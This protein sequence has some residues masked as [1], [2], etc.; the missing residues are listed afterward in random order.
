MSPKVKYRLY[1]ALFTPLAWLP[2]PVLY[3][4]SSALAMLFEHVLKYRRKIVRKNLRNAFPEKSE[5]ELR[6]IEHDFY[7]QFADNIVETVKLLS[8]SDR[9]ADRRIEVRGVEGPNAVAAEGKPVVLYLGHYGNW[10]YVTKI[11][12]HLD[13]P[14]LTQIYKPLR[15]KG[16]DLLMLKIRS[17]FGGTSLPQHYAVR[18]LIRW[19]REGKPWVCGFIADQRSNSHVNHHETIWLSQP[20]QFNPGGEEVGRHTGAEYFYID[21]E[22]PHRGHYVLTFKKIQP[23]DMNVDSPYTREYLRMLEQTIRRRPGLWL[24]SHRRWKWAA[25]SSLNN[26]ENIKKS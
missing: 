6:E 4:F 1:R 10:E 24:W 17:R 20:T 9:E 14:V 25:E 23:G 21:V 5:R 15:D 12:W 2:L 7:R 8:I 13:F 18:Q 16:F 22:K 19:T 3:A 26:S 11:A